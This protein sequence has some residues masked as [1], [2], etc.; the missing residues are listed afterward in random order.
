MATSDMGTFV[1]HSEGGGSMADR[2]A[3]R[4]IESR[5]IYLAGG[6]D[7]RLSARIVTG[8]LLLEQTGPEEPITMFLNSP[9]GSVTAG[10]A[11]YDT[12]RFVSSPLTVICAGLC[13]SIGT[14]ILL[15]APK[16]SRLALP[17]TR[18][19]I[20]QP[21]IP[22]HIFGPAS[23][24]EI[25]AKEI[26]KTR[27]RINQLLAEECNQPM[28]RIAR[29]TQRDYWMTAKDA[30]DYGLIDRVVNSRSEVFPKK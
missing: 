11:I 13:A 26:I 30:A 16:G 12:M 14:V 23:D 28:E 6:V 17:N 29:D 10:F 1:G 7:D 19:L 27:E 4:L 21:L 5:T 2:L 3:E 24:L 9:G 15:G 18:L 8:L 22:S 20:H 25:T